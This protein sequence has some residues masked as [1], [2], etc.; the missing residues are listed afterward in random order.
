[1]KHSFI[2][3]SFLFLHIALH[4][5]VDT[6]Y[7]NNGE[8]MGINVIEVAE[9]VIKFTYPDETVSNTIAKS[10]V[11][12]IHFKSGRVQEFSSYYNVVP[13]KSSKDWQKVQ[14]SK[15]ESEV[16]GLQK[17]DVIGAKATGVTT[18]TSIAKLQDRAF[19]KIKIQ[20]AMIGGNVAFIMH[21]NTEEA[22]HG[23]QYSAAKAPSVSLSGI[24]YTTKKV[25]KHEIVWGE[26]S[27]TGIDELKANSY[28]IDAVEYT[29]EN[30]K[31]NETAVFEENGFV[32]INLSI[33]SI[34]DIRDYT[35]IYAD[36]NE[37]ILSCIEVSRKGKR[38]YYNVFLKKL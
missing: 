26:Y 24:A 36:Q 1:M 14:I 17:I 38:T 10:S 37:V 28:S 15:I 8:K 23:T 29:N 30:V 16:Q 32:K 13:I 5:Q 33:R 34:Q 31:I 35:I 11:S 25:F 27:I 4:A 7:Q 2:T 20:T 12:K 18:L 3:L 19:D 21:Q 6:I 9:N 22:V